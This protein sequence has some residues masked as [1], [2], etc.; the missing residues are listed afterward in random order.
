MSSFWSNKR[1]LVTNGDVMTTLDLRKLLAFHSEQ[2]GAATIAV[3]KNQVKINLGVVQLDGGN[4][5]TGYIENPSYDYT[6]S[7]GIYVFEPR[8][9]QYI[10]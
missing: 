10:P 5:I 8:V 3:T 2:G 7:M 4:T 6:D 9:L 1:V